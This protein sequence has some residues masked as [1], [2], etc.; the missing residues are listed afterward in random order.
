MTIRMHIG[1]G[2]LIVLATLAGC[3]PTTPRWDRAFSHSAR[4]TFDAQVID[5]AAARAARPA[6][7]MDGQ[8]A[9]AAQEHYEKSF[10]APPPP[11]VLLIGGAK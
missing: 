9:R 11:P 2:A 7:G 5:P 3:A 8:T 1:H 10:G 6:P 4:A